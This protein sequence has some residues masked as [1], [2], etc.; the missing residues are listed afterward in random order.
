MGLY[1]IRYYADEIHPDQFKGGGFRGLLIR[2]LNFLRWKLEA[3]VQRLVLRWLADHHAVPK[4]RVSELM[5]SFELDVAA[6]NLQHELTSPLRIVDP[7][8]TAD[9][10][11]R[12]E[13]GGPKS[14]M[15]QALAEDLT[16]PSRPLPVD[17]LIAS[18]M[19]SRASRYAKGH[20][21]TMQADE[22]DFEEVIDE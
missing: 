14:V 17:N 4:T 8:P 11:E 19:T 6:E 5:R 21:R 18:H 2:G 13:R 12:Y 1:L 20:R 15:D 7:L 10:S 22:T 3:V 16:L 9:R